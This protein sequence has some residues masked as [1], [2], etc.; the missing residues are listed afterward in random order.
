MMVLLCI[1]VPLMAALPT[2]HT[3]MDAHRGVAAVVEGGLYLF[4]NLALV[5]ANGVS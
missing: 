5:E 2:A 3:T 4:A 1:Q